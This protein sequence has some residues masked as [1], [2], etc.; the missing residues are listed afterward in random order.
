MR[1]MMTQ[2]EVAEVKWGRGK[3]EGLRHGAAADR[4]MVSGQRKYLD[5]R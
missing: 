2:S 3:G 4:F 1:P 5:P